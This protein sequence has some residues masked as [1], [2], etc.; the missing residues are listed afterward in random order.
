MIK[1]ARHLIGINLLEMNP[2]RRKIEERQFTRIGTLPDSFEEY[3][4]NILHQWLKTLTIL[5]FT[6]VPIFFLLDY[7]SMPAE[8]L[9]R[10]GTYRLVSTIL[11][12]IQYFIVRHTKPSRLSFLH[13]YFAVINMGGT[14]A[15][16]TVDLGGFNSNYYA[17][18]NLVVV[19]VNLLLPWK[20]LH[21]AINSFIIIAMYI[22]FNVVA[23]QVFNLTILLNNLFF[24]LST[25]IIA[26]SINY[27]KFK[28]IREEFYL[29]VQLKMARDALWSE[30][31]LAKRIQTAL[32][33]N[34][35]N[36]SGYEIAAI[37]S[38]AREVGGDYY[39]IIET[40]EGNKW[41][42]MGDVSG[43]GVDSG[44]IM[45]MVQTSIF[46]L[47]NNGSERK[48]SNILEMANRV[49]RENISRLGSDHYMTIM[50][51]QFSDTQMTL[52][53]KHQDVILYRSSQHKTEIIPT[54]GTW[55]GIA[56]DIG[57]YMEDMTVD[58]K[59]GD[60]ILLFT[61][62]ITEAENAKGE[63]FGQLR[64]ENLLNEYADHPVSKILEKIIY[65]VNSF[66]QEQLDDMTLIVIKKSLKN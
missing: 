51:I 12:L 18:L 6:L 34:K 66:Q 55:L 63:M 16:M 5:G 65:D 60:L 58:L 15:L 46:G 36:I 13:G 2:N 64:L 10:F 7:F 20:Y 1:Q 38:P 23:D 27:V 26:V 17:G 22:G 53:G 37:M 4:N 19:G 45:M 49:I 59:D 3:Q 52:A 61:D 28:Q 56:D 9:P 31:E 54:K 29:L 8:L 48:P 47:V 21:S 30:M 44:L 39:D 24:M 11:L 43:H 33:P 40:Q 62:G 42:T 50:A 14:I 32:L 35:E 25:A 41:V 57:D